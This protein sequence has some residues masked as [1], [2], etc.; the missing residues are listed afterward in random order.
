M[1]GLE[2]DQGEGPGVAGQPGERVLQRV[3][4][5]EDP[6]GGSTAL[7]VE[8]V[9]AG[10]PAGERGPCT[11]RVQGR[12][13]VSLQP[14]GS[15]SFGTYF[16]AFAAAYWQRWTDV[17][18]VQLRVVLDGPGRTSFRVGRLGQAAETRASAGR[19]SLS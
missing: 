8:D 3:V 1:S 13:T 2:L 19:M 18:A 14:G 7:Y 4:L 9:A 12:R 17:R 6:D 10:V 11:W 16:N 5:P 15:V